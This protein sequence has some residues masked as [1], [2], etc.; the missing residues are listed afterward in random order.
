MRRNLSVGIPFQSWLK[1]RVDFGCQAFPTRKRNLPFFTAGETGKEMF[2][3]RAVLSA[4]P[5]SLHL[6]T[7]LLCRF[8]KPCYL[9]VRSRLFY[10]WKRTGKPI[11][12]SKRAY[13]K[14]KPWS[15]ENIPWEE[16]CHCFL[17]IG[18]T[19]QKTGI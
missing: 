11:F 14:F 9:L 5:C 3:V 7:A 19:C 17:K 8:W 10:D 4:E 13:D 1:G 16:S 12:F 6:S 15:V 2:F 18:K